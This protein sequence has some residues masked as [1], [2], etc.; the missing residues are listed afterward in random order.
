MKYTEFHR[1]ITKNGWVYS[2]AVGSHYFYTKNDILSPP[3]PYHGAKEMYEPLRKSIARQ[4]E[5]Q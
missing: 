3:V 5:L 1:R 4:M 2:H